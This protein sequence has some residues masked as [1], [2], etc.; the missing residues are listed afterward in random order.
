MII[1]K[2]IN[3]IE[4]RIIQEENRIIARKNKVSRIDI[5]NNGDKIIKDIVKN[6]NK[7]LSKNGYNTECDRNR[8]EVVNDCYPDNSNE[9]INGIYSDMFSDTKTIIVLVYDI[10]NVIAENV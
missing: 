3:G 8:I 2:K 7:F 6:V 9:S 1:E 4:Y 5:I 10:C